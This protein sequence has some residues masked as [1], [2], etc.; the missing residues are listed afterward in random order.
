MN[1]VDRKKIGIEL[2]FASMSAV[3]S[4]QN[5]ITPME[6][7]ERLCDQPHRMRKKFA[8][9]INS[10]VRTLT[11]EPSIDVES[12]LNEDIKELAQYPVTAD[13]ME[14]L[15]PF[16]EWLMEI[17][18]QNALEMDKSRYL[19]N[20]AASHMDRASGGFLQAYSNLLGQSPSF[21]QC[22]DSIVM[23][24]NDHIWGRASL[25]FP[26]VKMKFSGTFPLIGHLFWIDAE[27][28]DGRYF[29]SFLMNVEFGSADQHQRAL[30]DRNWV[31]LSFESACPHME[32]ITTDYGRALAAAG[33]CGHSFI[34]EWSSGVLYKESVVGANS[35]SDKEKE[36][37][38]IAHVF[39]LAYQIAEVAEAGELSG[40]EQLSL[41]EKV[42]DILANRYNF[43]RIETLFKSAGEEEL[44]NKLS[45]AVTAWSCSDADE[46]SRHMYEFSVLLYQ[47]E[48]SDTLRPLYKKIIALMRECTAEFDGRSPLFGTYPEA[49][50]KMRDLIE[51]EIKAMG[52]DGEYPHYRRRRGKKGEYISVLTGDVAEHPINGKMRYRFELSAA[53]KKLK[54]DANGT[55][56]A[57][58][59]PFDETTAEDCRSVSVKNAKFAEMGGAY[60]GM[61]ATI[62]V[63]VFDDV[64]IDN[65]FLVDN[66]AALTKFVKVASNSMNGKK[67]PRWYR[68]MRRKAFAKPKHQF[69]L[70]KAM[71]KFMPLGLYLT[72]LMTG[73]YLV[74]DE[75]FGLTEKIPQLTGNAAI[76]ISLAAGMLAVG[77]CSVCAVR[78]KKKRIWRY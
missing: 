60:D 25:V 65:E 73:A 67:S 45:D 68:K 42:T 2:L 47:K 23:H 43:S 17:Q 62:N 3:T 11:K 8:S 35:L 14:R 6:T 74:C 27:Y 57:A 1:Y 19:L 26:D 61:E 49:K 44:Y 33:K 54:K 36:L 10:G 5:E 28:R 56:L 41:P 75:L 31:R 39:R 66:A 24:A 48:K 38:P 69:T 46:T 76:G 59:M 34:D 52:F 32:F 9:L 77:V 16:F 51:P 78:S 29:F 58:G 15:L 37:L 21:V 20:D 13:T 7:V 64:S 55:Y 4:R 71:L 63:D 72:V 18:R 40:H 50:D 22:G 53:V 30:Q 12:Y 70:G